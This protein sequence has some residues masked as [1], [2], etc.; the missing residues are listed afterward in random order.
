MAS[1]ALPPGT[2]ERFARDFREQGYAVVR[3]VFSPEEVRRLKGRFD[4]TYAALLD[5]HG[6]RS[7]TFVKGNQRVWMGQAP[8]GAPPDGRFVRGCQWQSYEDAALDAVRTDARLFELLEPLIGRDIKQII[9]Q[10]HWKLPGSTTQWRYHQDCRS[11]KPDAAFRAL[12]ESYVQVGIAV[13]AF[14]PATG[15]M[16]VIPRSHAAGRDHGLEEAAAGLGMAGHAPSTEAQHHEMLRAAG[17]DP[18]ALTECELQPGDLMAWG[19]YLVHGGGLNT[20]VAAPGEAA[21]TRAFYINGYVKAVNCDRGHVAWLDGV[22]QPL[23]D[24]VLVQVRRARAPRGR[25]G[26]L[27]RRAP[28]AHSMGAGIACPCP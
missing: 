16:R 26:S 24:P 1:A 3:C 25:V 21:Q 17:L 2:A 4:A 9:N 15:G 13:E 28:S 22:P 12:A 20:T 19:P 7:G 14:T 27:L 23:G 18:A 8:E 10:M 11:R 5:A 6:A